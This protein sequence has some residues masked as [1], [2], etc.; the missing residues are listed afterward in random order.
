[1]LALATVTATCSLIYFCP[2]GWLATPSYNSLVFQALLIVSIG[3]LIAEKKASPQSIAGWILIGVGG[4]LAFMAKPTSAAALSVV[5]SLCLPL[6]GK[7]NLR[8]L[9]ISILTST[10]LLMT[11]A[12]VIDGSLII[13][14][15]RLRGGVEAFSFVGAKHFD[16]LRIDELLL[17]RKESLFLIFSSVI[18]F[19][20]LYLSDSEKKIPRMAGLSLTI[21]F[22]FICL[23][24]ISGHLLLQISDT[25]FSHSALIIFATLFSAGAFYFVL[26]R[27]LPFYK[28]T[29]E[30]SGIAIFFIVLPYVSAFGTNNNYWVQGALVS[31]FW[32]LAGLVILMPAVSI[33]S[34]WR[35]LLPAVISGQLITV[36]LLQAA[37]DWPYRQP[38]PFSQYDNVVAI[39]INESELILPQDLADYYLD[40]KKMVDRAG[41]HA[42]MPMIDMTGQGPGTLYAIG[43]KAI[44]QAWMIGG[45][46]GSDNLAQAMLNRV[47]CAE[48]A[49]A[50]L[51]V[52]PDSITKLSPTILNSSGLNFEQNFEMATKIDIPPENLQRWGVASRQLQLWKPT[53][54]TQFTIAACEKKRNSL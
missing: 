27:K 12:W 18:I 24:M 11:S 40:V 43:A 48:I 47:S 13:F 20:T 23:A 53:Q 15:D 54:P 16:M 29:Q 8:L 46:P 32:V 33:R 2:Y 39:G 50:W 21:L 19:G 44:A 10:I 4:W 3:F 52:D 1:M 30:Q 35:I 51:L 7:F 42:G 38:Q 49:Q 34:N 6:T 25:R 45:L 22:L 14:F 9:I 31:L 5:I 28:M 26:K 37:M 36:F 17:G 41:F